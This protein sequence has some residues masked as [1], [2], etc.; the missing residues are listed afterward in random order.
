M[1]PSVSTASIP[2]TSPSVELHLGDQ[3]AAINIDLDGIEQ[4]RQ[5]ALLEPDVKDRTGYLYYLADMFFT[6]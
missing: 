3:S 1:G 4:C 6:H 2:R 5:L